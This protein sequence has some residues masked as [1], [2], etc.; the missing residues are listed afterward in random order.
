MWAAAMPYFSEYK[1][2][3][4]DNNEKAP[5]Q[6]HSALNLQNANKSDSSI[7]DFGV[8]Q[9]SPLSADMSSML[10]P[11]LQGPPSSERIRQLSKQMKHA[12][13]LNRANRAPST[14]SSTLLNGEHP[15]W[16]QTLDSI[17]LSRWPSNRSTTSGTPSRPDSVQVLGKNIFHRRAKSSKSGRLKRESSTHSSSGSSLYSTETTSENSLAALKESLMPTI[18]ARRKSSRDETAMQKKA[19]ISGPFNFQHVTH[20]SREKLADAQR[21]S[22]METGS[23]RK[24]SLADGLDEQESHLQDLSLG[25]RSEPAISSVTPMTRASMLPRHHV[26]IPLHGPRRLMKHVRSQEQLRTS[27]PRPVRPPRSPIEPLCSPTLPPVPPPRVSSRQSVLG[28]GDAGVQDR[29]QTSGGFRHPQPFSP[30]EP[31]DHPPATS[32]GYFPSTVTE[33]SHVDSHRFSHAITTPDDAAWP[34]GTPSNASYETPLPDVP[35]EEE[36]LGPA[37]RAQTSLVSSRL[38]LRASQSVPLLR[39]FAQSRRPMS[40][41]SDTLGCLE[42]PAAHLT[43][44]GHRGPHDAQVSPIGDSWEDDIDY[45]YEHEADANFEYEWERPSMDI[46]QAM[47]VPAHIAL[48]DDELR[49]FPTTSTAE[50][51]PNMLNPSYSDVTGL[52]PTCQSSSPIGCEST[53]AAY[54]ST[55]TSNFSLPNRPTTVS[56]SREG[57][58]ASSY[59]E[60]FGFTLSPSLLIPGDY[61]HQMLLVDDERH[62]FNDECDILR[63]V[64]P[65]DL[66]VDQE[67]A[68]TLAYPSPSASYQRASVSTMGTNSTTTSDTTGERHISAN[69]AW[70]SLT[71]LTSSTSLN[72]MAGSWSDASDRQPDLYLS[73]PQNNSYEEETTPPAT[74]EMDTVPDLTPFPSI[75]TGKRSFH[76]SHASESVVRDETLPIKSVETIKGRRPRAR[77]T[78]LSAQAPPVGQYALFPRAY[79]KGNGD[80]I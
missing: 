56:H 70:T 21:G 30:D 45:C 18:F 4:S 22:R 62:E 64:G 39:G 10:E 8:P 2:S 34:L 41:A 61:H 76:K 16:E 12:S 43:R 32:H 73:D 3:S 35:E 24:T 48:V 1:T 68:R 75:Q 40:G 36:H 37:G 67:G 15:G 6:V 65:T 20:S 80:R 78:S 28:N 74:K 72:K 33:E 57:S 29:P 60:P 59:K 50:A 11:A 71:C 27:P 52:S 46:G 7:S 13:H 77:T 19:Q 23:E 51:S 25:N 53:K 44:N 54:P 42:S 38:S 47:P 26:S 49:E 58:R 79:V 31:L 69:S 66:D 14:G 5:V 9:S 55:A 17:S 63:V